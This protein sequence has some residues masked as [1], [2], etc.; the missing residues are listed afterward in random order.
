MDTEQKPEEKSVEKTEADTP[1]TEQPKKKSFL[2][3]G[4]KGLLWLLG[5]LLAF[6]LVAVLTLPFWINPVGTSLAGAIV[7][8][9]TGTAFNLERLNLNPYTGKL[10]VSGVR[11][12]NPEG[13]AETNAFALGSL[14]VDVEV[15]SLLSD[16][17]H[18]RDVT[19]DAPF[20]SY[21]LDAQGS[22][23]IERIIA[24]V[25]E[26][27]GPKKEKKEKSETK[28]VVDKVTVKNV[29]AVVGAGAF[30]L[31]SL[32]VTDFGTTNALVKL[33]DMKFVNPDGFPEP[34]AFSLKAL[35]IGVETADLKKKP[36][37]FHDIIVDSTY[38][39]LVYNDAGE[40]NLDVILKLFKRGEE[41]DEKK[42][43]VASD[44]KKD[45][46]E[47]DTPHV[48]IDK[49]DISGT[50]LQYRKLTVPIPLPTFN[51]IGKN[52][53][54]GATVKEVANQV[55]E[56]AKGSMSSLGDFAGMLGSGATN[57][58]GN[59]KDV[60]AAGATNV[61]GNAKDIVGGGVSNVLGGASNLLGGASSAI[62]GGTSNV[63]SGA[64]GL[65]GSVLPGGDDKK[66]DDKRGDDKKKGDNGPG[67]LDKTTE[68]AKGLLNKVNPLK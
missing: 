45:E 1:A 62:S 67:L 54:E 5:G 18:V 52:S 13:Y 59:A 20:A 19:V 63:L 65:L 60:I 17:I 2:R 37:V 40:S 7:P 64:K 16:T 6:I 27:L 31:A 38:A 55:M 8:V 4:L 66:E 23:N 50:K 56:K 3:R 28:V 22:N 53:K 15:S 49:L 48:M 35:S 57:L 61:L 14:S 9:F 10:L 41:K 43:E 42:E 21:V 36:I 32:V 46:K 29:R 58:L 47:D 26:K 51:D 12:A 24:A 11:L 30:E 33:E 68:G 34:N 25:N 44:E 39:G